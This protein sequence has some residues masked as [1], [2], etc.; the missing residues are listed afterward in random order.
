MGGKRGG[1]PAF[2]RGEQVT[3]YDRRQ[4]L[5]VMRKRE[6]LRVAVDVLPF[7]SDWD[8]RVLDVGAGQGA[9]SAMVLRRFP[10]CRVTLFDASEEMLEKARRRLRRCAKRADFVLGDFNSSEWWRSLEPPYGAVVSAIALHFVSP[11]RRP[12]FFRR[13]HRLLDEHGWVVDVD[14]FASDDAAI[15]QKMEDASLRHLQRQLRVLEGRDVP[16]EGLAERWREASQQ[17]GVARATLAEEMDQLRNAGFQAV[18]CVWR[19]WRIAVIAA[20]K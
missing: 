14:S 9:L 16:L 17:A 20:H 7:A 5:L 4:R 19:M 13:L 11:P 18:E 15:E 3:D 1:E 12:P 8:G 10:S 2:W 6:A